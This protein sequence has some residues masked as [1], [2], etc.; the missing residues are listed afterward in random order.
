[1]NCGNEKE[2]NNAKPQTCPRCG[3]SGKVKTKHDDTDICGLDPVKV[4]CPLCRGSGNV[5]SRQRST[6]LHH[7]FGPKRIFPRKPRPGR[8]GRPSLG[9]STLLEP[10]TPESSYSEDGTE[11]SSR[12]ETSSAQQSA[13]FDIDSDGDVLTGQEN[14]PQELP[15]DQATQ[16]IETTIGDSSDNIR[17]C[18]GQET[19]PLQP[20]QDIPA[21]LR[22]VAAPGI[23]PFSPLVL[24][25]HSEE[26]LPNILGP[27]EPAAESTEDIVTIP[28]SDLT[29]PGV[30]NQ[31]DPLDVI[32]VPDP[33][34]FRL[35]TD[36]AGN[37]GF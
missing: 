22:G 11:V 32:G 2:S 3:G 12:Q 15:Q 18:N 26:I 29:V 20:E 7:R 28:P 37:T 30:L 9:K 27:P 35:N 34:G 5:K 21:L 14:L 19:V 10:G 33:V 23:G 16:E 36:V 6:R 17:R 8:G 4:V 25:G 24:D 1:M 13:Q 31:L